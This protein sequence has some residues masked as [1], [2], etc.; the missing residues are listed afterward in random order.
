MQKARGCW[1]GRL[2]PWSRDSSGTVRLCLSLLSANPVRDSLQARGK[3]IGQEASPEA[4]HQRRQEAIGQ[5]EQE[6]SRWRRTCEPTRRPTRQ[7]WWEWQQLER[8]CPERRRVKSSV[9]GKGLRLEEEGGG[10]AWPPLRDQGQGKE[11]ETPV[12]AGDLRG[13]LAFQPP[14][15]AGE[16]DAEGSRPVDVEAGQNSCVAVRNILSVN[17]SRGSRVGEVHLRESSTGDAGQPPQRNKNDLC[18][19][20]QVFKV[21]GTD[22]L[23]F[24]SLCRKVVT[25]K[26]SI[27]QLGVSML[28]LLLTSPRDGHM[29]STWVQSLL[30]ITFSGQRHFSTASAPSGSCTSTDRDCHGF[31]RWPSAG[32]WANH[33]RRK[34]EG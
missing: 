5:S 4:E 21:N 27:L 18:K 19:L 15:L 32:D 25:F 20:L 30:L 12:V 26:P 14:V 11:V 6:L 10:E 31:N 22:T 23:E 2:G 8:R 9:E 13:G 28:Q 29:I 17:H 34:K 3:D 7:G 16:T 24:S 33:P 1:G